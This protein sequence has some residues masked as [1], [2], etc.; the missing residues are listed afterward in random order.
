MT[1]DQSEP[2]NNLKNTCLYLF[3]YIFPYEAPLLYASVLLGTA[4]STHDSID[5]ELSSLRQHSA[6]PLKQDPH[7]FGHGTYKLLLGRVLTNSLQTQLLEYEERIVIGL[8]LPQFV[9]SPGSNIFLWIRI[10]A[11]LGPLREGGD[12]ELF[13]STLRRRRMQQ[14]LPIK[15]DLK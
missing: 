15:R 11:V 5:V 14:L 7:S 6:L 4:S 8:E 2:N 3:E 12:A 13:V 1:L 10:G 9:F